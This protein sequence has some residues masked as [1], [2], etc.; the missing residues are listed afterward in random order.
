M[1]RINICPVDELMDQHLIAEIKEIPRVPWYIKRSLKTGRFTEN[2]IP[3]SYC[4]GEGHVKFFYNKGKWLEERLT[5][6]QLEMIK[7]KMN[8]NLDI[9][10]SIDIFKRLNFYNDYIPTEEEI[11][12]NRERIKYMIS[13][14]PDWYRKTNTEGWVTHLVHNSVKNSLNTFIKGR[15]KWL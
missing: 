6:V 1:T 5:A 9:S 7:R 14:K 12:I 13:L 11:E 2:D 8:P 15:N 10:Y 3:S 4:L